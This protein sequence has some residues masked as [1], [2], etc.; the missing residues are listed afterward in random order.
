MQQIS[1]LWS[2][3]RYRTRETHVEVFFPFYSLLPHPQTARA[4][5]PSQLILCKVRFPDKRLEGTLPI[6]ICIPKLS[7]VTIK[8][9][10]AKDHTYSFHI[11]SL[12]GISVIMYLQVIPNITC[13]LPA[14]FLSHS[15]FLS[16]YTSSA[17]MVTVIVSCFSASQRLV[18]SD[19]ETLSFFSVLCI[20]SCIVCDYS[21]CTFAQKNK[22]IVSVSL[23]LIF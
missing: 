20:F 22:T 6:N 14:L 19:L 4:N 16:P 8:L 10:I 7:E 12:L 18:I 5:P 11:H 9:I 3:G 15:P 17:S 13:F 1:M 2:A 21:F 23:L